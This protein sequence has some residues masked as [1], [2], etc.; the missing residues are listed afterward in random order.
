[1]SGCL[2]GLPG[3]KAFID[4]ILVFAATKKEHDEILRAVL[5][6][7]KSCGVTINSRKC[8]FGKNE[9]VFMGHR[10]SSE[11]ISPTE[12]KVETI[13]RCRDSQTSEELRSFLGLVNYLGK[14]IPDLATLTTPLRSL[15]RKQARFTWGKEQKAAFSKIKAQRTWDSTRRST[16]QSSSPTPVQLAWQCCCRRRTTSSGHL[17]HKQGTLRHRA[18]LRAK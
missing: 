12:D 15:L 18:E 3:V 8:E 7:L 16:R 5:D 6:R 13:K 9:V 1:M 11:G 17:L 4:D 14:F 2:T 10:L